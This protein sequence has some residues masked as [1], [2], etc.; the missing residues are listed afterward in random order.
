MLMIRE[1]REQCCIYK[2]TRGSL[3]STLSK[4][5]P[6]RMYETIVSYIAIFSLSALDLSDDDDCSESLRVPSFRMLV[7]FT[8]STSL[9]PTTPTSLLQST[10]VS[11]LLSLLDSLVHV[12]ARE[13]FRNFSLCLRQPTS[14][15]K[16][17]VHNTSLL[18]FNNRAMSSMLHGTNEI[19]RVQLQ[20]MFC[21]SYRSHEQINIILVDIFLHLFTHLYSPFLRSK[22]VLFSS[23]SGSEMQNI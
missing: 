1:L 14:Q 18:F 13:T 11:P 9:F 8:S 6:N 23:G 20:T 22:L 19:L 10:N 16:V 21:L 4:N 7:F 17:Y 2:D 5:K 15:L 3:Q 12:L